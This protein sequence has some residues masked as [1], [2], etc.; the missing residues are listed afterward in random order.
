[1]IPAR[2]SHSIRTH[3]HIRNYRF[4]QTM[5]GPH[6]GYEA[7]GQQVKELCRLAQRLENELRNALRNGGL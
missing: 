3:R 5:T 4:L 7:V 6:Q 2:T 1:M